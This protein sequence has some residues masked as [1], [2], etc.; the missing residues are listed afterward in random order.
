M[1]HENNNNQSQSIYYI[2]LIL[3][4]RI[5]VLFK[6]LLILIVVCNFSN[7]VIFAQEKTLEEYENPAL[8]FD[9]ISI[10]VL[11]EGYGTFDLDVIYT[12]DNLLYINIENLFQN[13]KIACRIGQNADSIVGFIENEKRIYSIEYNKRQI[14]VGNKII[15]TNDELLKAN[16]SLYLLSSVLAEEFG[17][18]TTFNFRSMSII[19]KSDFELP[20]IKEIREGKIRNNISKLK[21]EENADTIVKRQYHLFRFGTLD[22]TVS[23]VQTMKSATY[24]HIG[25]AFGAELLYGQADVSISYYDKYKFDNR[26]LNYLWRW[27][28]NDM[29]YIK[30]AHL[31]KISNQSI[32]F[33]NAPIIGGIIRN[34]PTTV[35]KAT[36]YYTINEHTEPNWTV[37]LYINN[38]LTDY[39]KA[40]ASGLYMFKVP[41]VYGYTVLKLKFYGPL[42]EERTDERT[43]N[44]P[45]TIMPT[46][47]FEYTI[48][49]GI[50]QDSA[51]SRFIRTESIY[52][53]NR[54]L[55]AG[56][57]LEYLSSITNGSFIP[58]AKI[59]FQPFS[60]ITLN[61][62][63]IHGVKTT[64]LLNYYITR[65]VLLEADYSKYVE[66]QQATLFNATEERKIKISLPISF[67]KFYGYAKLDYTQLVY[68]TYNYNQG[69]ILF[70]LYY[71]QFSA[72][73]ITQLNWNGYNTAYVTTD[74]ALSYRLQ[75]GLTIR[76]SIQ[77]NATES[78]I[79][80][81]KAI[82][83]KRIQKGYISFNYERYVMF[84][85]NNFSLNFKYDLSFARTNVSANYSDVSF[86][87][88]ESA[89]GSLAFGGG[90][91]YIYTSNNSS[92]G[93]GGISFYPFLDLNNNG[94]FDADEK[95]VKLSSVR[96]NGGQAI[97]NEN[98][99]ILRI[100]D[101]NSF[102]SYNVEFADN[103]LENI[104]W[105][106][107]NKI[108][109]VF[110]DPNQ[111]KRIDVPVIVMG[112]ASGKV[113]LNDNNI[114]NG[115]GRIQ[116]KFYDKNTG[117]IVAGT[118]SEY[119]G[120]IYYMG[121]DPG[122]Y[123]ARVDSVQ[124]DNLD[125]T[126]NPPQITFKVRTL[127]EGD[128]IEGIDFV[129]TKK[130]TTKP[131]KK[132][133]KI[134]RE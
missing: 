56:G 102:I 60:D 73:S 76:P 71:N 8:E 21:R 106:F 109:S 25:T 119:D 45:Y 58:Y 92:V 6:F 75:S 91:N 116:I 123:I 81:F 63:Y 49:A 55:T 64:G 2:M 20:F 51:L 74:L 48:T 111:F 103:N 61:C 59:T 28:D 50:V 80:M 90:N 65:N 124:L 36:G 99:S 126:V 14:Q 43:M 57:G 130:I 122:E 69:N 32:S 54:F 46:N 100:P 37:E 66:G 117:K 93:K 83:E 107:K 121:L 131:G 72:N 4:V 115:I 3:H 101:L 96:I 113:Y 68:K 34:S 84:N 78:R 132:Q 87:S 7:N 94:I 31:G 10:A 133:E 89:Q 95:M 129:L 62:E 105:R 1:I 47:E 108:Y 112:E 19:L 127:Q 29:K 9:E 15:N 104:A 114:L 82:I 52:G 88:S 53:V 18:T 39:S 30:Q 79:S 134:F 5:S 85:S 12:K 67:Q 35:R 77:Y 23:S 120:Y 38:T 26:H 11:I 118:L 97:I 128:V 110:I 17:I 22:W 27:V 125:Y 24:N 33:I 86:S 41:I 44:V 42:G 13:L 70:S 98:D 16:G 40:D